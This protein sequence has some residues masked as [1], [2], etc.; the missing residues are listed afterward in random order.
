MIETLTTQQLLALALI[1]AGGWLL[2]A[3]IT[4]PPILRRRRKRKADELTQLHK[5]TA[6]SYMR[7]G[8]WVQADEI[9]RDDIDS[10][11]TPRRN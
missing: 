6:R 5:T 2:I 9:D 1:V 7:E 10:L 4:L 8:R 3:S 11:L